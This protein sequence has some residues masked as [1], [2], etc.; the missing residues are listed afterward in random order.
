MA[1]GEILFLRWFKVGW[2][3][4]RVGLEGIVSRIISRDDVGDAVTCDMGI[5][6]DEL[7][8]LVEGLGDQQTVERFTVMIRQRCD[9]QG[10]RD[11]NG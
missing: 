9:G 4:G 2:F 11:G 1:S 5:A 8:A 6:A 3:P 10:E 7:K